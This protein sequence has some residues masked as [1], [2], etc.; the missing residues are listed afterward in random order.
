[1][2]KENSWLLSAYLERALPSEI[3]IHLNE[4]RCIL[5][6]D[7]CNL[8]IFFVVVAAE[9]W[10]TLPTISYLQVELSFSFKV[11]FPDY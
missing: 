10:S 4:H 7:F 8:S 11:N 2:R 1:M 9:H 5:K 6:Y 3:L